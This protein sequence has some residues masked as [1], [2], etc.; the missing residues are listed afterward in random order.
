[1]E[2]F[3][4]AGLALSTDISHPNVLLQGVLVVLFLTIAAA[5]VVVGGVARGPV[6]LWTTALLAFYVLFILLVKRYESREP[7]VVR[8]RPRRGERRRRH[9]ADGEVEGRATVTHRCHRSDVNRG[10]GHTLVSGFVTSP[11][12]RSRERAGSGLRFQLRGRFAVAE[13]VRQRDSSRATR[14]GVS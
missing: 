7:W 13:V 5:G 10:C 8:D 1:M 11:R 3:D 9:Q 6:G 4:F 12:A 2:V 14:S